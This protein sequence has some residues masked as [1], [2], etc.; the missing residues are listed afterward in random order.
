LW[1]EADQ[2]DAALFVY[3]SEI[4]ADG[5]MRYVTEGVLRALHRQESPCPRLE[6]RTWP[7]HGF[8]RAAATP[9]IKGRTERIRFALLPT[10]WCF[11]AGSR[12]RVAIAGADC[13]HYVQV[14]HGRPPTLMIR[15]GGDYA[16][17]IELPWRPSPNR[18]VSVGAAMR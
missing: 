18:T 1:L 11:K 9:M 5:R 13:D 7:Y 6:R 15:R 3:L 17:K 14:P 2:G 10:S 4:E 12:L 16:S 8:T